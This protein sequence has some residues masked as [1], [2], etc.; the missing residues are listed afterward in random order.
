MH[1]GGADD[2]VG[3]L[4]VFR[5]VPDSD[6][7]AQGTQML[8]DVAFVGVGAGDDHALPVK[9]FGQRGHGYAADADEMRVIA[10][11]E[12]IVDLVLCHGSLHTLCSSL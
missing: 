10:G 12:I 7:N 6:G 5:M 2:E 9:D 3:P 4:H 1:G 11:A 8:N